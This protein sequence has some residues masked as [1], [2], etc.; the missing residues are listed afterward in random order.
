MSQ[1]R[2]RVGHRQRSAV[3]APRFDGNFA[4]M[5]SRNRLESPSCA[6][7]REKADR[8]VAA[9]KPGWPSKRRRPIRR[10]RRPLPAIRQM[11]IGPSSAVPPRWRGGSTNESAC[12][13]PGF[14]ADVVQVLA[15]LGKPVG[16]SRDWQPIT[17]NRGRMIHVLGGVACPG[18]PNMWPC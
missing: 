6:S 15:A 9:R 1:K 14:L 7:V 16:R 2:S 13:A 4:A 18:W 5:A 10:R 12:R 17:N 3:S 11:Q 8:A